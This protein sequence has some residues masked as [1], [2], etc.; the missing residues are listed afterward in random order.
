M[1]L[2]EEYTIDSS[3]RGNMARFFNVRAVQHYCF[4]LQQFS[5]LM[6]LLGE[7][8]QNCLHSCAPNLLSVL[9]FSNV[10]LC[11]TTNLMPMDSIHVLQTSKFGSSMT[12]MYHIGQ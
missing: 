3:S 10:R 9:C 1:D 11:N 4:S 5:K 7:P 2:D 6:N 8:I 12:G